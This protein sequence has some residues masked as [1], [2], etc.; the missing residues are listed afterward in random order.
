VRRLIINADDFGLTAGVN[1]AILEAHEHGVVTSTT[2]MANSLAFEGAVQ[3]AQSRFSLSTGCH[4]V[5]LDEPGGRE[6]RK[7]F[8]GRG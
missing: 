2:L 8:P 1:R 7:F 5:L 4:V 6:R 3:L